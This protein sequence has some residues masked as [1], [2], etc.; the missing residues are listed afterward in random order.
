MAI[1][2]F[3]ISGGMEIMLSGARG[4]R[5]NYVI[6]ISSLLALSESAYPK[7]FV[8]LSPGLRNFIGNPLAFGMAA[9][10]ALSV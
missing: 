8:Q 1:P 3:T 6:G 4:P 7:Y 9:A 5:A 2:C 10:I